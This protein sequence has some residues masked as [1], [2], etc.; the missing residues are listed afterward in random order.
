MTWAQALNTAETAFI[1]TAVAAAF[2]AI[3][4]AIVA[5]LPFVRK[6]KPAIKSAVMRVLYPD[7]RERPDD[8][9]D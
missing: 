6:H 2:T 8:E 9:H 3:V 4:G 5:R 1:W 7:A